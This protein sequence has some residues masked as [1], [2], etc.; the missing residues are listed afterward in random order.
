MILYRRFGF[1]ID[2][3]TNIEDHEMKTFRIRHVGWVSSLRCA[4]LIHV[5]LFH[6][7]QRDKSVGDRP[8][9]DPVYC[10]MPWSEKSK[11]TGDREKRGKCAAF[12]QARSCV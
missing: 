6:R 5:K 10:Q 9:V 1:D 2:V 8:L 11:I 12:L 3:G 7:L 4:V